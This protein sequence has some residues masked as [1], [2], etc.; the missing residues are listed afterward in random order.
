LSDP[1][2]LTIHNDQIY[3]TDYGTQKIQRA[4]LNL[5]GLGDGTSD[6]TLQIGA[7]NSTDDRMIFGI[8]S[9]TTDSL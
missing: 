9:V 6:F 4:D 5:A 8:D 1:N 7:D 2:D 3:W